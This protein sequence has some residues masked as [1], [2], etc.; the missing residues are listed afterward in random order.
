MKLPRDASLQAL[1][2]RRGLRAVLLFGP[3]SGL[4]HERAVALV[5]HVAGQVDDPF[6]V[7]ELAP[8]ALK[9]DPAR[10][11][12]EVAAMSLTGGRR[13]VWIRDAT[14]GLAGSALPAVLEESVGDTVIVI[15]A[16]ELPSRSS[17]RKLIEGSE[18]AVAVGC[19]HDETRDVAAVVR[20]A[21]TKHGLAIAPDALRYLT[22]RMGGDRLIT[23]AE[24]DK[25]ALYMLAD[26]AGNAPRQVELADAIATVGDSAAISLDDVIA[27]AADGRTAEL[28]RALTRA[29]LDGESPVR[30]V[31]ACLQYF[32]RLHL[33]AARIA[34]GASTG[35]AVGGLRP[36]PFRR[37]AERM[38]QQLQRWSAPRLRAALD[39]LMQA[40]IDCKSTALPDDTMCARAL[41]DVARVAERARR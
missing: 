19:Y 5:T 28:E 17:L 23:R 29:L 22:E 37:D 31:R 33:A 34:G 15:E 10:L 20:D 2:D 6:R 14:D 4:A 13:A 24:L 9:D 39:R 41:L 3:D 38:A 18:R 7:V 16:G 26:G 36:P 40:E 35:D 25:L 8:A 32:Q 12:D 21:L 30:V 27:A 1:V 11:A